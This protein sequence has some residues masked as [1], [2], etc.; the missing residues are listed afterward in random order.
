M[1]TAT[2]DRRR[3]VKVSLAAIAVG[4]ASATIPGCRST[5][6]G[7]NV[8]AWELEG[9]ARAAKDFIVSTV[10]RVYPTTSAHLEVVEQFATALQNKKTEQTESAEYVLKS[11]WELSQAGS[12]TDEN[13]PIRKYIGEQFLILTNYLEVDRYPQRALI[14][15]GNS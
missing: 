10:V 8:N 6:P 11:Y 13:S 4:C 9:N 2:A 3:F 14:Y 15:I 1:A 12:S 7:S 5:G